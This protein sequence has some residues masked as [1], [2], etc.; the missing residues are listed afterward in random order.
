MSSDTGSACN[1]PGDRGRS[2]LGSGPFVVMEYIHREMDAVDALNKPEL[3]AVDHQCLNPNVNLPKLGVLYRQFADV[4]LKLS[5][6]S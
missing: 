2:S 1:K 5:T 3:S 4:L 6:L